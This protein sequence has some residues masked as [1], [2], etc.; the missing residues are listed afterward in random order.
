MTTATHERITQ[1]QFLS[2]QDA[3]RR[4]IVRRINQVTNNG[5]VLVDGYMAFVNG[6][7]PDAKPYLVQNAIRDLSL[8]GEKIPQD[9][10]GSPARVVRQEDAPKPKKPKLTMKEIC[11]KFVGDFIRRETDNCL[12]LI[13]EFADFLN[14][15]YVFKSA[16]PD[17]RK[18]QKALAFKPHHRFA[19]MNELGKRTVGGVNPYPTYPIT[20]AW[21]DRI[22]KSQFGQAGNR[23]LND[24]IAYARYL[25]DVVKNDDYLNAKGEI[26]DLPYTQTQRL[27]ALKILLYYGVDVPWE[28]ITYD[29]IDAYLRDLYDSER[30]N[31]ERLIA[32]SKASAHA[33]LTPDQEASVLEMFER[34]QPATDAKA[35]KAAA[36]DGNNSANRN[37]ADNNTSKR[38]GNA[39]NKSAAD[40]TGKDNSTGKNAATAAKD[41]SPGNGK[42]ADT[43]ADTS[44]PATP[45]ADR[46]A[47]AVANA[48]QNHPEVDLDTA[49]EN[50]PETANVPKQNLTHD[51]IYRAVIA[52]ANF[53]KRQ[54][55]FKNLPHFD[56]PTAPKDGD[57]PTARSP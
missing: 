36:L 1:E 51:L 20:S 27:K 25:L 22:L 4:N 15:P 2:E 57:P 23:F 47:R 5:Q 10:T 41:A 9:S 35:A 56:G 17:E 7:Y 8:M 49:L 45:T 30:A 44:A 54:Q 26:I 38:N 34:M 52:E 28:H 39:N 3:V 46:G 21:E 43:A 19:A 29:A 40:N 32:Q 50:F 42:S 37:N 13:S 53:Q 24:G 48:L 55:K 18:V 31:A 12:D 33:E 14:P 16:N 11:V 6:E